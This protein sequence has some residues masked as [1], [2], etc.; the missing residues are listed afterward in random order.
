MGERLP[1]R[2]LGRI[3]PAAF[4]GLLA[5]AACPALRHFSSCRAGVRAGQECVLGMYGRANETN[6]GDQGVSRPQ[7]AASPLRRLLPARRERV[8]SRLR[9]FEIAR[10]IATGFVTDSC[11]LGP[12]RSSVPLARHA[13]TA[14]QSA[15]R[16]L[17]L[18]GRHAS[19]AGGAARWPRK[20]T[21]TLYLMATEMGLGGCAVSIQHRSVR[22]N[23]RH[24][25]SCG[26]A[27]RPVCT[28]ARQANIG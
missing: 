21:Q 14:C 26:R 18:C 16:G 1:R 20:K 8:P 12:S 6:S 10:A 3:E 2:T 5:L 28:W 11:S 15:R 4:I 22:E 7:C 9:P 13:R 19:A 23:D 24:R 17:S 25:N 27:G